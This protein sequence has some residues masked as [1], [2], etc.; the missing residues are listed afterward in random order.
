[1]RTKSVVLAGFAVGGAILAAALMP[2]QAHADNESQIRAILACSEIQNNP[3]IHGVWDAVNVFYGE[4]VTAEDTGKALRDA[5]VQ[6]PSI[7]PIVQQWAHSA[8]TSDPTISNER[9]GAALH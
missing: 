4:N 3:T 9:V 8:D 6:C 1:M 5:M 7:V 2:A